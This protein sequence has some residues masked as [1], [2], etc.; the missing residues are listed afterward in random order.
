MKFHVDIE[1]CT[2]CG[3]CVRDC[4]A[5]ALEMRGDTP[6][7]ARFG[8]KTC[9]KCQH[10]LAVCPEGAVS[11]FGKTPADCGTVRTLPPPEQVASLYQFRRSCR[12]YKHANIDRTKLDKLLGLLR[13][14][15]T[16]HND[17]GLHFSV[18]DDV[19]AMDGI[20][21]FFASSLFEMVKADSLPPAFRWVKMR[22]AKLEQ[23][24]DIVFANA[25]HIIVASVSDESLCKEIDPIIALAQF[26]TLAQSLG[27][28]TTWCGL[29]FWVFK[30]F[31]HDA[32]KL[33][34]IPDGYSIAYVMLFGDPAVV[35]PRSTSQESPGIT[36]ISKKPE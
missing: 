19:D 27:I 21:S 34:Q 17:R 31:D 4:P 28:G 5:A 36:R 33:L 6:A 9:I 10:C 15:P 32:H 11:I 18:V 22:R 23:G 7:V 1:K 2:G 24:G 14:T 3:S 26:E 20:R 16:G 8:E 29:A 35:Y 30:L 12:Q 13:W 25:P